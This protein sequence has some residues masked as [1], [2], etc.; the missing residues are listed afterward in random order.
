MDQLFERAASLASAASEAGKGFSQ[1]L[2]MGNLYETCEERIAD[3]RHL[4]DSKFEQEK[5]NALKRLIAMISKGKDVRSYFPD[6]VKNVASP[7]FE[8]RKLVYIYLLRYAEE[9]PDLSLL[10]INTFQKDMS[11]RNPMIRAMALRVMSSIRVPMIAPLIM[12]ALKKGSV[13]MSPYVRKATANAIPKVYSLSPSDMHESC[14]ELLELLMNDTSTLVLGSAIL[15][16]R[17]IAPDRFDL[18]HRHYRKLCTLLID[19]DEWAQIEILGVLTRY[20][21]L[22]FV[23]PSPIDGAATAKDAK[24]VD[25]YDKSSNLSELADL[26]PDHALLIHSAL[27][28]L[29]SRNAAVVL[30]TARLLIHTGPQSIHAKPVSALLRLLTLTSCEHQYYILQNLLTLSHTDPTLLQPHTTHF[31]LFHDDAGYIKDLKLEILAQ[32]ACEANAM[33]V[34]KELKDLVRSWDAELAVKAIKLMGVVCGKVQGEAVAGECLKCLMGLLTS[35]QESIVAESVIVTRL[36]LQNTT[37]TSPTSKTNLIILLARSLDAIRV[38]MARASILWLIGQHCET[39]PKIAHDC[40][41]KVVKGFCGESA[42]VKLQVLTMGVKLVSCAAAAVDETEGGGERDVA[43]DQANRTVALMF[44]HVLNLARYDASYDVRDRARLLK[45][46]WEAAGKKEWDGGLFEGKLKSIL[47]T[48]KVAPTVDVTLRGKNTYTLGS[49][50][51]SFNIAVKGYKPLPEWSTVV[52]GKLERNIPHM[53]SSN[54]WTPPARSVSA[55]HGVDSGKG[56]ARQQQLPVATTA[57][58]AKK[59]YADLSA[60]LDESSGSEEE[61]EDSSEEEEEDTDEEK[62]A[63][64][65]GVVAQDKESESEYEEVE[66]TDDEQ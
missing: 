56:H 42:I 32:I 31:F 40:F 53:Q 57:A 28:L 6:V 2:A 59:K 37:S 16:M 11:D 63:V 17:D 51:H 49:L 3:I 39:V 55:Q 22:F 29:Q 44:E 61:E 66:V 43:M 48:P 25:F 7:S 45:A 12:L 27:P 10:S 15:T 8:V 62:V 34:V 60:F 21:R 24:N 13:D 4:L 38:P 19:A 52:K 5:I 50:S 9:E 1:D 64:A 36:L 23:D 41:R 20:A 26:D 35:N 47:L 46:L 58:A 30:A 54:S 65:R 18:V 14:L 33:V